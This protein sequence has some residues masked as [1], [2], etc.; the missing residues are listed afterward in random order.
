MIVGVGKSST[1]STPL[2]SADGPYETGK[3]Q[4]IDIDE[5]CRLHVI[6][7]RGNLGQRM[8]VLLGW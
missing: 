7:G 8:D 2:D 4:R 5:D 6:Y 1:D 3:K